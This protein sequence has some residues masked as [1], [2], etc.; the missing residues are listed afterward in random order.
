MSG[1][2]LQSVPADQEVEG[3]GHPPGMGMEIAREAVPHLLGV[4]DHGRHRQEGLDKHLMVFAAE[5]AGEKA[6]VGDSWNSVVKVFL[7]KH[8]PL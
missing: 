1:V 2:R 4:G 7:V 3:C 8:L 5:Q 6:F